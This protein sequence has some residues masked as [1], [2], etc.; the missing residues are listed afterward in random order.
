MC[1]LSH[2]PKTINSYSTQS[3]QGVQQVNYQTSKQDL[4]AAQAQSVHRQS[5][6]VDR[7][8]VKSELDLQA[9]CQSINNG[10]SVQPQQSSSPNIAQAKVSSDLSVRCADVGS[11]NYRQYSESATSTSQNSTSTPQYV[12]NE[13]I[14]F[15][16]TKEGESPPTP[17]ANINQ[18]SDQELERQQKIMQQQYVQR[19]RQVQLQQQ[20]RE[21]Q[22]EYEANLYIEQDIAQEFLREQRELGSVSSQHSQYQQQTAGVPRHHG[23]CPPQQVNP[24]YASPAQQIMP[25]RV[26]YNGNSN[27]T[28]INTTKDGGVFPVTG[29]PISQQVYHQRHPAPQR[30][31]QNQPIVILPGGGSFSNPGQYNHVLSTPVKKEASSNPSSKPQ[32]PF[33]KLRKI[34]E[35]ISSFVDDVVKFKGKKGNS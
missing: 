22:N 5:N 17:Q 15:P 29:L 2:Q 14:K 31:G 13:S 9:S 35:D 28:N 19:V 27:N 32:T 30:T 24:Q 34:A 21:L 1:V 8:N 18:L 10:P 20:L 11:N 6:S 26:P 23:Q 33:Q 3:H 25:P 16:N 12:Y 7:T 4:Y